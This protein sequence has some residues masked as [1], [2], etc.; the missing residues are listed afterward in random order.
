MTALALQ[1]LLLMAVAYFLGAALACFIRRGLHRGGPMPAERRVD[2]LPEDAGRDAVRA[3]L[4][5]TAPEPPRADPIR[6][7]L[8]VRCHRNRPLPLRKT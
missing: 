7:R 3:I 1:A 4:A 5:R 6:R 2:P 8:H